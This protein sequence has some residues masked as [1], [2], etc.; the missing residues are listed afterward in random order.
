MAQ[1][2]IAQHCS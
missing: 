2:L 1:M